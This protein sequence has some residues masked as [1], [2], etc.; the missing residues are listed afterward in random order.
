MVPLR[1]KPVIPENVMYTSR[2]VRMPVGLLA[3]NVAQTGVRG[4]SD[5]ASWDLRSKGHFCNARD[6]YSM[7]RNSST[8]L[9]RK[10]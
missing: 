7:L 1:M 10:P 3:P 6:K 4:T 5:N 2:L 8:S 9:W